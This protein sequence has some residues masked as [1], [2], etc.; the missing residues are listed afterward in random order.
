MLYDAK[1]FEKIYIKPGLTDMRKGI[2]GLK[3]II[4]RDM[5]LN[6]YQKNVLFLFC[7]RNRSKI[8]GLI[9]E[10]DG[11]LLL[12]KRVEDGRYV[13]PN[14]KKQV[15]DLTQEQFDL[16]ISGFAIESTIREMTP[17]AIC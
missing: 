17:K 4:G 9:W 13:W 10:G 1:G 16:L 14:D 15:L 8:R 2:D 7:G 11:F 5:N 12:Y 3:L 6:P